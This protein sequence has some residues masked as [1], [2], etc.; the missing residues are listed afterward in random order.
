MESTSSQVADRILNSDH[1]QPQ[2]PCNKKG[3]PLKDP[4]DESER[5]MYRQLVRQVGANNVFGNDT[6]WGPSRI[7][8]VAMGVN[9]TSNLDE[10]FRPLVAE[11]SPVTMSERQ[12]S[13]ALP[14]KEEV[15]AES[16]DSSLKAE[17]DKLYDALPLMKLQ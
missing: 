13:K 1:L 2:A 10:Q 8:A 4:V 5:P 15:E 16:V 11:Q 3:C 12:E 17:I 9:F 6:N 14:P 7:G